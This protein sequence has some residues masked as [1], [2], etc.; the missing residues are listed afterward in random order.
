PAKR[1]NGEPTDNLGLGIEKSKKFRGKIK[2]RDYNSQLFWTATPLS[3]F[4]KGRIFSVGFKGRSLAQP[5]RNH[6]ANFRVSTLG[7]LVKTI[8]F[9]AAGIFFAAP[10]RSAEPR[11]AP[12]LKVG[13]AS[14]TGGRISLWA[15]HDMEFFA[16]NGLE[17][18]L[19]YMATSSQGIPALLAGEIP[20]FSGSP[21]TAAQ[22]NAAGADLVIIASSEP[23]PYKLIVQPGIKTVADLKGKRL[24]VDRVGGSSYYATRRILEKLGL[25]PDDV[26]YMQ[27][28]GGGNQRVAAFQSGI[29]SGVVSTIERFERAGVA[30]NV[31]ADAIELGVRSIG[32]SYI[33]SRSFRDRNR[34]TVQRFITAL[35]EGTAWVKNPKNRTAVL[36]I[37]GRRLRTSD[38]AILDLNYRIY[39]DALV[40]L[41]FTKHEDLRRNFADL[42]ESNP[43]L[44]DL[45]LATFVDNTFV[46]RVQQ[47]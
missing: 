38:P 30:Y 1:T 5:T 35:V 24:G 17:T 14:I 26:E 46:E 27:V 9:L 18:E 36:G 16:R 43:R 23:T 20:I 3:L 28:I 32:S 34:D 21:E 4:F 10:A 25:K 37:V 15:T 29:L 8:V 47:R 11:K 13:Y 7:L 12:Y 2:R 44:R 45:N 40:P 19:I 22:A 39:V 31:L 41:P 33:T 6:V 42:A